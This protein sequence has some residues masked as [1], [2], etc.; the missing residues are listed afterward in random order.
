MKS[1]SVLLVSSVT[2]LIGATSACASELV[3][4]QGA[5]STECTPSIKVT[6]HNCRVVTRFAGSTSTTV[7]SFEYSLADGTFI[8]NVLSPLS[9]LRARVDESRPFSLICSSDR[10]VLTA[11]AALLEQLKSGDVLLLQ[12]ENQGPHVQD[13]SLDGFNEVYRRATTEN[14]LSK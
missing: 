1:L 11:A 9:E 6:K 4:R 8:A 14:Q 5:W 2:L 7:E 12:Y 10:C 13:V 3:A